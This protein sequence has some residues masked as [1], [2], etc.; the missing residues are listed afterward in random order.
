MIT[1]G[2]LLIKN[3]KDPDPA[4]ERSSSLLPLLSP[5]RKTRNT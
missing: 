4:Q 5:K 1:S 2:L 3:D